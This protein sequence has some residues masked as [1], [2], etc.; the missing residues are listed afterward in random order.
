MLNN[1]VYIRV[2]KGRIVGFVSG[3]ALAGIGHLMTNIK[4][5]NTTIGTNFHKPDRF[6]FS[7]ILDINTIIY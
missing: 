3:Q 5:I 2:G 1:Q 7:T 4:A 6:C